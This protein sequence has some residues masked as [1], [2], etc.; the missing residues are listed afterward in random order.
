MSHPEHE[1]AHAEETVKR[2]ALIAGAWVAACAKPAATPPPTP[3]ATSAVAI[4]S[5]IRIVPMSGSGTM[6]EEPVTTASGPVAAR[7]FVADAKPDESGGECM[8]TR[9]SGNG[10]LTA[11]AFYPTRTASTTQVGVTFDSSGRVV[12]Y[13][14]MRGI[15]H[16]PP[17]LRREQ[18][19]SARRAIQASL[20]ST[21]ISFDYVVDR[22]FVLNR[23]AGKPATGVTAS[24]RE[25]ETLENLGRPAAR[26][27]RMRKLCGV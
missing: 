25:M 5:A 15:P 1:R 4:A 26:M 10:A 6:I 24:V 14:E 20:R 8:L 22:A 16:T 21:S 7:E 18:V 23:G 11:T 27:E 9:T 2:F 19:D 13:F 17:G 3:T 12:R